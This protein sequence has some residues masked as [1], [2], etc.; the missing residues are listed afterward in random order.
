ME[1]DR[2]ETNVG[3][4]VN[5]ELHEPKEKPK[6]PKKRFVGRRTVEQAEKVNGANGII[7]E[8]GAIQGRSRA[9]AECELS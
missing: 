5:A 9:L 3:Q 1:E 6:Q 2:A 7:E 8:N 4:A